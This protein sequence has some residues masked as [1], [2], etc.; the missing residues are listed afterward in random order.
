[1]INTQADMGSQNDAGIRNPWSKNISRWYLTRS[2][3]S[4]LAGRCHSRNM[5]LTQGRNSEMVKCE[6]ERPD[7]ERKVP[8]RPWKK[9]KVLTI[10]NGRRDSKQERTLDKQFSGCRHGTV[11]NENIDFIRDLRRVQS[12]SR[13]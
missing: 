6:P 2:H 11:L 3:S 7:S 5:E 8:G 13:Q 4:V 12:F 9:N 10:R 1:M